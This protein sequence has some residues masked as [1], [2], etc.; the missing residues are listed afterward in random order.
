ME[1]VARPVSLTPA[2]VAELLSRGVEAHEIVRLLV[3][4]GTWSDAGPEELVATLANSSDG[5]EQSSIGA[6]SG[7]PGPV[8][9]PPPLFTA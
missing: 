6:E 4:T 1:S 9:E 5:A 8:D 7:W 3:A 2:Q